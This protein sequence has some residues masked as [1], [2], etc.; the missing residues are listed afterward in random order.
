MCL[1]LVVACGCCRV[2]LGID[3]RRALL[4]V[5]L[6]VCYCCFSCLLMFVV[7][8]CWLLLCNVVCL[9]IVGA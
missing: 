2:L 3:D 5:V 7:E 4:A 9:V 6:V 1:W 8:W